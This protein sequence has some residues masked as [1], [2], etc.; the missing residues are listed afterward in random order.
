MARLFPK[1]VLAGMLIILSGCAGKK[2]LVRESISSD[3]T[4]D[5]KQAFALKLFKEGAELLY[6]DDAS[7]LMRFDQAAQLD[8]QL[9]PAY[10]NAG[11][12]LENLGRFE[13][14]ASRY[15]ACLAQNSQQGQCLDNLLLLKNRLG[16]LDEA[17]A[18]AEK[19]LAE[20]P[21]A[22]FALIG[23]A[24]VSFY[25]KDLVRA[26]RF[27]RAAIERDAENIE[28]LYLMARIFF[29]RERYS[30]AKWI[31][32]NAL[33]K[34]PA[35]GG[36]NLL[37]GHTEAR[38]EHM[39]DALDYYEKAVAVEPSEE[40]LENYGLLLLKRGLIA[41]S[42]VVLKRLVDLKPKVARHYL[43][44]GNALL[45]AKNFTD[46]KAAYLYALELDPNLLDVNFNLGLLYNDLKPENITNLDRYTA[47]KDYFSTFLTKKDLTKE[48]AKETNEYLKTL[49][50]KI[51]MEEYA[52]ESAREA[53]EEEARQEQEEDT[54]PIE[55]NEED[56]APPVDNDVEKQKDTPGKVEINEP[57]LSPSYKNTQ[58]IEEEDIL[59]DL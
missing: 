11:L 35:H 8:Q 20:F 10:F 43:H 36:L 23:M 15:E 29:A 6:S 16:H 55:D 24:K 41:E 34:A 54:P 49:K 38:L 46:A 13:E 58:P 33:E 32:K 51:E 4:T 5:E 39:H 26:E 1:Y 14:A 31:L 50:Q 57:V 42:L 47:A 2:G 22:P 45:A 21:E 3:A 19:I 44:Y 25:G 28:G 12:A 52:A 56:D 7:A 18:R 27:A 59:D 30:T 17:R 37:L 53:A 48:Q 9:I 40:S